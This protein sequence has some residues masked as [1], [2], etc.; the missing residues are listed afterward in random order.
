MVTAEAELSALD[1][2]RDTVGE[3][4]C[5]WRYGVGAA[6]L[7]LA[8]KSDLYDLRFEMY[9]EL[10]GIRRDLLGLRPRGNGVR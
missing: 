2:K 10:L 3:E 6:A 5:S 8:S 1:A 9:G 4:G 7:A